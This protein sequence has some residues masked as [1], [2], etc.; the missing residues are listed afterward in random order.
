MSIFGRFFLNNGDFWCL[1]M[2]Y[3][4]VSSSL[5]PYSLLFRIQH[6]Q[7]RGPGSSIACLKPKKSIMDHK[8]AIFCQF[9]MKNGTFWYIR[10]LQIVFSS[11]VSAYNLLLCIQYLN[12]GG[13]G[14]FLEC[15]S[16]TEKT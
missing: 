13:G 4:V 5:C 9:F 7:N 3:I 11:S 12:I 14:A 16:D 15:L 8:V 6:P 2:L 10:M 1:R